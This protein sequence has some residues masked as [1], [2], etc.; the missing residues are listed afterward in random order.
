MA[1]LSGQRNE[2][3]D[4]AIQDSKVTAR[5]GWVGKVAGESRRRVAIARCRQWIN[6]TRTLSA[7]ALGAYQEAIMATTKMVASPMHIAPK[8]TASRP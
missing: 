5:Y 7:V 1:E 3:G 2:S 6:R 8:V 4:A